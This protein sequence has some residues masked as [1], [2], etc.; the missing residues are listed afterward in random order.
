[1]AKVYVSLLQNSLN[2]AVKIRRFFEIKIGLSKITATPIQQRDD[3]PDG[4]S[5]QQAIPFSLPF[6]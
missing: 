5:H 3:Q 4:T 6:P 2:D 1:M